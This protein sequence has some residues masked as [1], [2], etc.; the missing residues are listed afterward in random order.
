MDFK[1]FK[2]VDV[3]KTHTI[4]KHP[5]GHTIQVAHDSLT[6]E[7]KKQMR[8]I[9]IQSA[10]ERLREQQEAVKMAKGGGLYANIHAKRERIAEG[11]GEK[12]RKPGSEGAPTEEAFKQSAKTAKM[13]DGGMAS[14]LYFSEQEKQEMAEDPEYAKFLTKVKTE[15][16]EAYSELDKQAKL[17]EAFKR[18]GVGEPKEY[19]P[20]QASGMSSQPKPAPS[21][22]VDLNKYLAPSQPQAPMEQAVMPKSAYEKELE[23]TAQ[24]AEEVKGIQER[25]AADQAAAYG[26]AINQLQNSAVKASQE[27]ERLRGMMEQV[28][29]SIMEN[30]IDPNRFMGNMSTLGRIGTALGLILGGIGKGMTGGRENLALRALE[31]A[32]DRDIDAQ[33]QELGKKNNLLTAYYK[34]YG[35]LEQAEAA[36]K[37]QIM[38][39]TQLQANQ[40]AARSKSQQAQQQ[41]LL[42]QA[43]LNTKREQYENQQAQMAADKELSKSTRA[44]GAQM[45]SEEQVY[46]YIDRRSLPDKAKADVKDAYTDYQ[47]AMQGISDFKE[48]MSDQHLLSQLNAYKNPVQRLELLSTYKVALAPIVKAVTGETRMSDQEFRNFVEPLLSGPLTTKEALDKK[49][50]IM[51]K[52]KMQDFKRYTTKLKG[53]GLDFPM[54]V[55]GEPI[56]TIK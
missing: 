1:D 51:I 18:I 26:S 40:I 19:V 41:N 46:S 16:P 47:A 48:I 20:G 33:K 25:E 30:Q 12:M 35:D 22:N 5:N 34:M 44:M 38:S 11:S 37:A 6:P 8:E 50:D 4:F 10:K 42:F 29:K 55:V 31:N 14:D 39:M 2:K 45:P 17:Q 54:P 3:T 36:T 28:N 7:Q 13:A 52:S 49:I 21:L 32:I 53:V 15:Y 27:K 23:I 9:P 43:Q 24:T 56:K